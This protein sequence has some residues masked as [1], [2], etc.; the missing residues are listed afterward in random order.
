MREE[1]QKKLIMLEKEILSMKSKYL[2]LI[3]IQFFAVMPIN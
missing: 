3:V 1:Y 2:N